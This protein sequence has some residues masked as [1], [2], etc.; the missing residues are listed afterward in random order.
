MG[1]SDSKSADALQPASDE[2]DNMKA[3][4]TQRLLNRDA[5]KTHSK[6]AFAAVLNKYPDA[7]KV[8]RVPETTSADTQLV[9]TKEVKAA[10]DKIL[11]HYMDLAKTAD[12]NLDDAIQKK[13]EELKKQGVKA[14]HVKCYGEALAQNAVKDTDN[15]LTAEE[16]KAWKNSVNNITAKLTAAMNKLP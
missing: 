1:C 2:L 12:S 6:N 8:F 9:D 5:T 4:L 11:S 13:A 3:R 7:K 16:E 10:S 15:K 14:E